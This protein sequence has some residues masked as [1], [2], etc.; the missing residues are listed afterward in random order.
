MGLAIVQGLLNAQ[1][2]RAAA[3]NSQGRGARF[4]IFVPAA[5]RVSV[6]E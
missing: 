2:G 3:E 6:D 1:G 5:S 4:S